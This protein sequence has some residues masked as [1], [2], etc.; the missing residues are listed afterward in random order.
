MKNYL[1][2]RA[3]GG[4]VLKSSVLLFSESRAG[5]PRSDFSYSRS[6]RK[7]DKKKRRKAR[8]N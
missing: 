6:N 1:F 8:G 7:K 5:C 3:I 2:H 4:L